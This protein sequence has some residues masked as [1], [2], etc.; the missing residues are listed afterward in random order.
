MILQFY[1][2]LKYAENIETLRE[3]NIF[4]PINEGENITKPSKFE[5]VSDTFDT[6]P[7]E[8]FNEIIHM[9]KYV[10]YII[11]SFMVC[12]S[13]LFDKSLFELFGFVASKRMFIGL[14]RE[15]TLSIHMEFESISVQYP[16][17]KVDVG[18]K[19][20]IIPKKYNLN[21][22]L[23]DVAR[24]SV[25]TCAGRGR[26][27]R[28]FINA[29][30]TSLMSLI[31]VKPGLI[32]PKCNLLLAVSAFAKAEIMEYIRQGGKRGNV[33][34][35]VRKYYN[36]DDY[37]D[38]NIVKLVNNLGELNRFL[39]FNWDDI[40]KRYYM[41]YLTKNDLT[42]IQP[43]CK[44]SSLSM[45]ENFALF[46]DSFLNDLKELNA[47]SFESGHLICV[48]LEPIRMNWL[49][50][51]SLISTPKNHSIRKSNDEFEVLSQRMNQIY[52]RSL[53]LDSFDYIIHNHCDLYELIF[54]QS[55][56]ND[57]FLMC[58]ESVCNKDEEGKETESLCEY[59]LCYLSIA[60]N[61]IL[62]LH[63]D[64]PSEEILLG[65]D[66]VTF[67]NTIIQNI[68]NTAVKKFEQLWSDYKLLNNQ[69]LPIEAAKQLGRMVAIR[70]AGGIGQP[71][72]PP[73][74]ESEAWASASIQNLV[75]NKTSLSKL[76]TVIHKYGQF[77]VFNRLYNIEKYVSD[78]I[79][80]LFEEKL[81][82]L[83]IGA[84]NYDDASIDIHADMEDELHLERPSFAIGCLITGIYAISDCLGLVRSDIPFIIRNILYKDIID[85]NAPPPGESI[86]ID[87]EPTAATLIWKISSSFISLID[88]IADPSLGMVWVPPQG[89][90]NTVP[91]ALFNSKGNIGVPHP[92]D[93]TLNPNDLT[94]L[95]L[96]IGPQGVKVIDSQIIQYIS[97]KI[98]TV[99]AFLILH[100][101]QLIF[102]SKTYT[103]D[104]S[105]GQN[106]TGM[107]QFEASL[108]TIGIALSIR[109]MLHKSL[110]NS[111]AYASP[112]LID[113]VNA[114]TSGVAS[115]GTD[116]ITSQLFHLKSDIGEIPVN[117]DAALF[118]S[119]SNIEKSLKSKDN[120]P[121]VNDNNSESNESN[122]DSSDGADINIFDVLPVAASCIF[123]N[124][125]WVDATY[126]MEFE[127]FDGNEHCIQLAL[128]KLL[129]CFYPCILDNPLVQER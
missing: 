48:N 120:K 55:T 109:E 82:S 17:P 13:M 22:L 18:I 118:A 92:I 81:H 4:N 115:W 41:E 68:T 3:L 107:N 20:V 28:A 46:F 7:L 91:V 8:A 113:I 114:T 36:N 63:P 78:M 26:L 54:F 64:C 97:Y 37:N 6:L 80:A 83:F 10:E 87:L 34:K 15:Y 116:A 47:A 119:L 84:Y 101:E 44:L 128:A 72:P 61:F 126:I 88:R 89:S 99:K 52:E 24:T 66:A 105:N 108:I 103:N 102:F 123:L 111:V 9:E 5:I 122:N 1:D 19:S 11:F 125:S 49:R 96:L 40:V 124:K 29:E 69:I 73:G 127:A 53:Y 77:T 75:N 74:A 70:R 39:E 23:K 12:P 86:P 33:R 21:R 43:L 71:D 51:L 50:V 38:E 32:A 45:G 65:R 60:R 59:S 121:P 106:L 62:N 94:Q 27:R 31:R 16:D 2:S 79:I 117:N 93:Q 95:C 110:G 42:S 35:D 25:K 67:T 85:A 98:E 104:L 58:L 100:R 76:M 112:S 129:S 56:I 30:M 57:S 90:Y 14:F